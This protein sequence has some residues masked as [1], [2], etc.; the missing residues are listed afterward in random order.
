[1]PGQ[2]AFRTKGWVDSRKTDIAVLIIAVISLIAFL[3]WDL[4]PLVTSR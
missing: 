4:I 1:M 2:R 3:L